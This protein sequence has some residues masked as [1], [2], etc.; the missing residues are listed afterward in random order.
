MKKL[1][2]ALLL[3]IQPALA[4]PDPNLM[5]AQI[6]KIAP[7]VG[8]SGSFTDP[9]SLRID[10]DKTATDKQK[11]AA[12]AFL[13]NLSAD[14]PEVAKPNVQ[15]FLADAAQSQMFAADELVQMVIVA[16]IPDEAKRNALIVQFVQ[17]AADPTKQAKLV[18]LAAKNGIPLPEQV[19]R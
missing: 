18:E 1:F 4:A 9:K 19:K 13:S 17:A 6:N 14:A 10:F 12:Q 7:I 8:L 15:G 2:I 16:Q 3:S 5:Y 11:A